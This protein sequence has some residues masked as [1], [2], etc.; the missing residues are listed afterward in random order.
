MNACKIKGQTDLLYKDKNGE[1]KARNQACFHA[2]DQIDKVARNLITPE[3]MQQFSNSDVKD[4]QQLMNLILAGY[5]CECAFKAAINYPLPKKLGEPDGGVDIAMDGV[6]YDICCVGFDCEMVPLPIRKQEGK[7]DYYIIVTRQDSK[8]C[9]ELN[10]GTVYLIKGAISKQTIQN[11]MP[12][13]M[14]NDET[15]KANY[16]RF[17]T[18]ESKINLAKVIKSIKPAEEW[19]KC[20]ENNLFFPVKDAEGKYNKDL[21]FWNENF[22]LV[23]SLKML[24]MIKEG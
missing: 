24:G 16:P 19:K 7:A 17:Y 11:L 23:K 18:S 3:F 21:L 9:K 15:I 20:K 12:G 6:T 1:I 22:P 14:W 10:G 5:K 13:T 4:P 8:E 2:T